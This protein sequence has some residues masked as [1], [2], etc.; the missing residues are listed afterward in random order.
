MDFALCPDTQNIFPISREPKLPSLTA[1]ILLQPF[2]P[3]IAFPPY[4]SKLYSFTSQLEQMCRA[5]R[6]EYA[7]LDL[8]RLS[9]QGLSPRADDNE[10]DLEP[11]L[12]FV[13]EQLEGLLELVSEEGFPLLLLHVF[14]FF[15]YPQTSFDAVYSLLPLLTQHMSK[16]NIERIFTCVVIRLFDTA[17][18]PHHRGQ[19]YS[20]TTA[21]VILKRFGLNM[22]LNRFLG[23]LIEVVVEPMRLASSKTHSSKR[24][25][26]N[27]IRM[28][29]QSVLTLMTSDLLQ[30]QVY[31][32]KDGCELS[33]NLSSNLSYS[34]G[35][36]ERSYD[37]SDK[38]FSSSEESND[39]VAECSLLAKSSMLSGGGDGEVG[40]GGGGVGCVS[41]AS[42]VLVAERAANSVSSSSSTSIGS[43]EKEGPVGKKEQLTGSVV[44]GT[45]EA[46]DGRSN[47]LPCSSLLSALSMTNPQKDQHMLPSYQESGSIT[48]STRFDPSQSMA[49]FCSEDSFMSDVRFT[50]SLPPGQLKQCGGGGGEGGHAE[51]NLPLNVGMKLGMPLKSTNYDNKRYS[52]GGKRGSLAD[53]GNTGSME[54]G[55]E[56][57]VEEE[58]DTYTLAAESTS[59]YDPELLAVNLH[60]SEVAGDCLCWLFRR[61]GPLLSSKHIVRPLVESLHRCFT[62]VLGLRGKEVV[63]LKCLSSFAECYGEAVVREMYVP[64]AESMVRLVLWK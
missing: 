15:Q 35:I 46:E 32:A 12:S 59:L 48:S 38:E 60:V 29:S 42:L 16:R 22:F 8:Q 1:S 14:P 37:D 24:H 30:S 10:K 50:S 45:R 40:N 9:T 39:D 17:T 44:L 58:G 56:G 19:L 64:H 51:G 49:S 20:R 53:S 55:K 33:A 18:E 36:S 4:F 27:I 41:H 63:A 11:I 62:G 31:S 26:A 54:E 47:G 57:E 43:D 25:N 7:T 23:F 2:L 52:G 3:I 6:V 21:N 34:L 5:S 13:S 28:K 61:L